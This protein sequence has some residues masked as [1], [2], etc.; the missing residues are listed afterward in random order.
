MLLIAGTIQLDPAK[1]SEAGGAFEKMRAATLQEA[2]CVEY[3]AYFDRKDAGVVFIFE[4]WESQE[5]LTAHFATAHMAEF[6]AALAN[7]GVTRMD[8]RKY[9]V[10]AERPVS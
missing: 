5:A 1:R 2:G 9:E 7:L 8:L 4:K 10:S 6:G 3:Q